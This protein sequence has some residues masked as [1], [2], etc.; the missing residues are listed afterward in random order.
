MK[1]EWQKQ[2]LPSCKQIFSKLYLN[3]SYNHVPCLLL[4]LTL[5]IVFVQ[6]KH[7]EVAL[8]LVNEN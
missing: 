6:Q 4:E 5:K 7:E 8:P 2:L 3:M 1:Y